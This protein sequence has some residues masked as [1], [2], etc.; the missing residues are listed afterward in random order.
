M[1]KA[2]SILCVTLTVFSISGCGG[3]T[4]ELP[5]ATESGPAPSQE[6]MQ[7]MMQES[8]EKSGMQGQQLPSQPAQ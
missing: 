2:L 3:T 7:K 4:P 8:M 5:P 6:E 1:S